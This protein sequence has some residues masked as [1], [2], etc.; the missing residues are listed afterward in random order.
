LKINNVELEDMD[1]M[2]ADVAEKYEIALGNVQAVAKEIKGTEGIS[3]SSTIRRQ[4]NTV[5]DFFNAICG[6][7]TDKKIFGTK[8]NL[9]TCL[10]AFEEAIEYVNEQKKQI[11][12]LTNKY[13]PNRAQKRAQK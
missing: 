6:E 9:M 12:T 10:K 13:S 11:E 7:G 3:L 5:F 2:D 8:V 1:I 4:C